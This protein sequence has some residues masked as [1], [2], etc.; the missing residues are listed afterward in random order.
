MRRGEGAEIVTLD[1]VRAAMLAQLRSRML[2]ANYDLGEGFIVTQ[3]HVE[4]RLHLLDEVDLKQQSVG[5]GLGSDELHRPGQVHHQG[6]ALG[7]EPALGILDDPFLQ[8][9][10]LADIEDLITLADHPV[11]TRGIGQST[12]HILNH[13]SASQGRI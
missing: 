5:L 4:P 3:Q 11:D 8:G 12:D 9:P 1:R 13:G 10:R 6:D 7:V 2:P